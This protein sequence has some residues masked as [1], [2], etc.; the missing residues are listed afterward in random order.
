MCE[1]RLESTKK[2]TSKLV[3][4]L[5]EDFSFADDEVKVYFSGNRDYCV[6]IESGNVRSLD[7]RARI[8]FNPL[9]MIVTGLKSFVQNMF[10]R[11]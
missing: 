7:S 4:I 1:G 5:M 8:V 3:D 9:S 2:E 10:A 6:Y 11:A